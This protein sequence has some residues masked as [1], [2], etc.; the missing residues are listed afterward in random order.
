MLDLQEFTSRP[1][2]NPTLFATMRKHLGEY[3]SMIW[4]NSCWN[5]CL[6]PL[7]PMTRSCSSRFS[8]CIVSKRICLWAESINATTA[9]SAY[10]NHMSVKVEFGGKIGTSIVNGYIFIDYHSW[11]SYNLMLHL[12]NY[13]KCYFCFSEKFDGKKSIWIEKMLDFEVSCDFANC[14]KL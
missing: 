6:P 7:T 8:R 10:S 12:R 1:V 13:K 14:R 3:I 11:K 5:H 4:V 9:Y 2:F